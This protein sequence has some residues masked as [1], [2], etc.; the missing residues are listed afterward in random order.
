MLPCAENF[1]S[2]FVP[3]VETTRLSFLLDLL[4]P[5]Q[6][7]VMFVGNS[8]ACCLPVLPAYVDECKNLL[9]VAAGTGPRRVPR[10]A[11]PTTLR[12]TQ[13]P[14]LLSL[15][16]CHAPPAGTGKTAIMQDKLRSLDGDSTMSY[17]INLNSQHDGPSLQPVL[18]APLEKKSGECWQLGGG[19]WAGGWSVALA[20]RRDWTECGCK[21][22]GSRYQLWLPC[23]HSCP[24]LPA[25]P[26]AG[27]RFG[28]PG[29]K[30][31]IYFA[32]G[33]NMPSVDKYDTQSAVELL[34]QS[35]DY[36]G[37]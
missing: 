35:I 10:R 37:W 3:T 5:N 4:V 24:R 18:E 36:H 6:H 34:R 21:N 28:P 22:S 7:H 27:M 25:R 2:L 9:F 33:L 26:P 19:D 1:S 15:S 17:T 8:G 29:S 11:C 12:C 16:P 30:R 20:G 32:D 14:L 23:L 13:L 31:L